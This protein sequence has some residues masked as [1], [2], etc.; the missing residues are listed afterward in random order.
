MLEWR[1]WQTHQTQNLAPFTG[2]GVRLPPPAPR[3]LSFGGF[4]VRSYLNY[5]R[6]GQP[7]GHGCS[8]ADERS[9]KQRLQPLR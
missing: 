6:L 3:Q 5:G 7:S 8:V 2:M 4:C 1:N 9:K